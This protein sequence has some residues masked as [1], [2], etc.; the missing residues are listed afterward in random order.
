LVRWI[1]IGMAVLVIITIAF[2][3]AAYIFPDFRVATRDIAIVLLGV[4]QMISVI[5][6][7]ALL[8]A[9]IYGVKAIENLAR[10]N[11]IPRIDTL[12]VKID[13]VI[14]TT[15]SITGNVKDTTQTVSNTTGYVA[16]R[17]VTPFVR[18]SGLLAGVRAAAT[19]LARRDEP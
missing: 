14:D 10:T 9:L 18:V 6:M 2:I 4:F 5:L 12:T 13:E 15:R 16:E 8:L 7:I 17:V 1:S 19:Y 11:L 3:A